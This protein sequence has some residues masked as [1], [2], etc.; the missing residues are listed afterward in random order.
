MVDLNE[1]DVERLEN[2]KKK[3]KRVKY[4]GRS[5]ELVLDYDLIRLFASYSE[6]D[7]QDT[8]EADM[9]NA[10]QVI[11]EKI[12]TKYGNGFS[13]IKSDI[14]QNIIYLETDLKEYSDEVTNFIKILSDVEVIEE[15]G[16]LTVY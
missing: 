7:L 4:T 6:V 5:L 3:A 16:K 1:Q 9:E 14:Y 13:H 2:V 11:L 8:S 12:A 15:N 10:S